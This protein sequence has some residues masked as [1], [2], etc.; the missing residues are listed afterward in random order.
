MWL[1]AG[2]GVC[3]CVGV[4]AILACGTTLSGLFRGLVK[5]PALLVKSYHHPFLEA[6]RPGSI[7][8][9]ALGLSAAIAIFAWRRMSGVGPAWLG[10]LKVAVGVVLLFTFYYL[11][12]QALTGSLLFSWLLLVD[13][14]AMSPLA[15][16]NRLLLALLCPLF[17]LQLLPNAGTQVD[18]AMLMP[19]TAAVVMLADGINC[20]NHDGSRMQLSRVTSLVARGTAPV[21]AVVLFLIVGQS[22]ILGYRR[23]LG[24][25]PVN[26][27]GTHW[28]RLR[29]TD[30]ARLAETV[31]ELSRHCRTVLTI[32]GLYSYSLWSGVPPAEEKRINSW[33]FLWPQEVQKN[34]LPKLRQQSGGCVLV[35]RD[36]YQFFRQYATSGGGDELLSEVERTMRPVFTSQGLTLYEPSQGPEVSLNS[37]TVKSEGPRRPDNK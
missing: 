10:L 18:W 27:P 2:M 24:A 19:I 32:P 35:D 21:I 14:R 20:I 29:S 28:L 6:T 30:K 11:P 4:G 33:P 31:G 5:D 13:D 34:E 25:E 23:W 7:L 9:S 22:A 12:R 16:S 1:I 36:V 26:L 3:V 17:S 15:Y 37:E 8:L